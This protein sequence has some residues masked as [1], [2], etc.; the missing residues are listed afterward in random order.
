MMKEMPMN[1]VVMEKNNSTCAVLC[2]DGS[3]RR[4]SG[5][6]RIGEKI[7][8]IADTKTSCHIKQQRKI[9]KKSLSKILLPYVA[10]AAIIFI[11]SEIS[12]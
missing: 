6:F 5:D 2:D 9:K 3:F 10:P 12:Y 1:A 7:E 4:I 8:V 11:G